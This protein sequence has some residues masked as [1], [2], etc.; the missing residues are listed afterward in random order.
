MCDWDA[1]EYAEYLLWVEAARATARPASRV[2]MKTRE[3][4]EVWSPTAT[5]AVAAE[6]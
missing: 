6:T 2:T 4:A 1:K 5:P 3:V